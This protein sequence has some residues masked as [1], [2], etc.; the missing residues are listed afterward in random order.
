MPFAI[1]AAAS[2]A[3]V[4]YMFR[5]R[6]ERLQA[7]MGNSMRKSE[8]PLYNRSVR[9]TRRISVSRLGGLDGFENVVMA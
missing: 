4:M 7:G 3:G 1:V 8:S 2:W 9:L 5:H 6:G